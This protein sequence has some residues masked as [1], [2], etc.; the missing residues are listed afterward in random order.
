MKKTIGIIG[1]LSPESTAVYYETIIKEY[2][3]MT[4]GQ[5][6]PKILIYSVDFQRYTDFFVAGK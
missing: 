1:G 2:N 3:K 4:G 5:D 6:Y